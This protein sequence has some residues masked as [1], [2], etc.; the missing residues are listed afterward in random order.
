MVLEAPPFDLALLSRD[1]IARI[2]MSWGEYLG[3]NCERKT[4]YVDGE[5]L[6]M[7]PTPYFHDAIVSRLAR[8]LFVAFPE[9]EALFSG[10]YCFYGNERKP[11]ISLI[12]HAPTGTY[13]EDPPLVAVEVLSP[14]T[15]SEDLGPKSAQYA[16]TGVGQYWIVDPRAETIWI[17]TNVNG[18]W[19][20]TAT[21]S[22]DNPSA[23]IQVAEFGPISID[24]H[25]IFD[26]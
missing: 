16:A 21:I 9:L 23:T 7:P 26:R 18:E 1:E 14:S 12:D 11:D 5:V 2:P 20:T 25:E 24:W 13:I 22:T 8:K 6:I 10:S 4:E 17:R 15:R 19:L 3:F